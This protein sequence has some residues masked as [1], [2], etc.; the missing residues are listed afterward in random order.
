[1]QST[2]PAN[3]S[4]S[5]RL[6]SLIYIKKG[7]W[8]LSSN[9]VAPQANRYCTAASPSLR[10]HCSLQSPACDE[11]VCTI[12]KQNFPCSTLKF[13]PR[14]PPID[15]SNCN[16][17][18]LAPPWLY[19]ILKWIQLELHSLAG[20]RFLCTPKNARNSPSFH[21]ATFLF[22]QGAIIQKLSWSSSTTIVP[23]CG[24]WL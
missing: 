11:S 20:K 12:S 13:T 21:W 10:H 6:T 14:Y 22:C 23:E 7:A 24:T 1:M 18:G 3:I 9:A 5:S 17:L 19:N 16:K 8:I 2:V 15:R 4:F